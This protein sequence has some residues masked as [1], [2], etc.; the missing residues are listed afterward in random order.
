MRIVAL[1][2]TIILRFSAL[3]AAEN[4]NDKFTGKAEYYWK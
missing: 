2:L 4:N 1:C 3:A